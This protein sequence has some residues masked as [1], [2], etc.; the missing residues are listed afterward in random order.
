MNSIIK[1]FVRVGS[2]RGLL[3]QSPLINSS[4]NRLMIGSSTLFNNSDKYIQERT[5]ATISKK[6]LQQIREKREEEARI[7]KETKEKTFIEV[8][9]VSIS[10]LTFE[11]ALINVRE[12][13]N[14]YHTVKNRL[15]ATLFQKSATAEQLHESLKLYKELNNSNPNYFDSSHI[16]IIYYAFFR[17]NQM[18]LF[19][20]ILINSDVFQFFPKQNVVIKTLVQL[21]KSGQDNELAANLLLNYQNKVGSQVNE[22]FMRAFG[23]EMDKQK[24]I[25]QLYTILNIYPRKDFQLGADAIRYLLRQSIVKGNTKETL[26]LINQFPA[27]TLDKISQA[28]LL[29]AKIVSDPVAAQSEKIDT[30]DT[31]FAETVQNEIMKQY[32]LAEP[33]VKESIKEAS[34]VYFNPLPEK[35]QF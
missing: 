11:D 23:K 35:L 34:K 9:K 29:A 10:T 16:L 3:S 15:V 17:T 30:N 13:F 14:K 7:A 22:N 4:S 6:K 25:D 1:A 31:R 32:N 20:E 5:Y 27:S 2:S 28:C 12:K 33:D 26:N 8:N 18:P 21:L 24:A 19:A